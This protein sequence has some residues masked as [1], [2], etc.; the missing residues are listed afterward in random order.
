MS[1]IWR[2]RVLVQPVATSI[3]EPQGVLDYAF[4]FLPSQRAFAASLI[5]PPVHA[6]GKQAEV[7]CPLF[8][9]VRRRI[10]TQP[11]G[12]L[13]RPKAKLVGR[14]RIGSAESNKIENSLLPPMR[15]AAVIL[16]NRL[17]GIEEL[18]TL[19]HQR[20]CHSGQ[21]CCQ[22]SGKSRPPDSTSRATTQ[23]LPHSPACGTRGPSRVRLPDSGESGHDKSPPHSR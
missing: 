7:F 17:V 16:F 9:G 1:V 14:E 15:Q 23:L 12:S 11:V 21:N 2:D 4:E 8:P 22:D 18:V 20:E 10:S 6:G 5:Q 3:E 19:E 13:K